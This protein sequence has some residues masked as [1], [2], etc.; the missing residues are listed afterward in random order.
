VK[1]ILIVDDDADIREAIAGVL[2]AAGYHVLGAADGS[3]AWRLIQEIG[4]PDMILL[5]L[6]MPRMNGEQFLELRAKRTDLGRIPVVVLTATRDSIAGVEVVRKPI[7]LRTLLEIV[8]NHVGFA[9]G[10]QSL[11]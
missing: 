3:D 4:A 8:A 7:I 6:M 5:D 1:Q 2:E 10:D 11:N 9:N